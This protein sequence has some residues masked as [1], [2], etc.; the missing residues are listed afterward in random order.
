[1][2]Q[3]CSTNASN[4]MHRKFALVRRDRPE[5]PTMKDRPDE[6]RSAL[7]SRPHPYSVEP[8]LPMMP[9]PAPSHTPSHA[10][11]GGMRHRFNLQ[12]HG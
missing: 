4:L 1:M 5:T 6:L 10:V 7:K 11:A 8:I 3:I 12:L 2:P 9:K